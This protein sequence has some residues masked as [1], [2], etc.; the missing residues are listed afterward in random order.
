VCGSIKMVAGAVF[1]SKDQSI[2]VLIAAILLAILY[3][4]TGYRSIALSQWLH[5]PAGTIK[6]RSGYKSDKLQTKVDDLRTFFPELRRSR[7]LAYSSLS[8]DQIDDRERTRARKPI[9]I[10]KSFRE[11]DHGCVSPTGFTVSEILQIGDFPDY[12]ALSGFPLPEPAMNFDIETAKSRP[13]RP[14]RWP[15][16]QTMGEHRI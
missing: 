7:A 1:L 10:D 2:I 14:F 8:S 16:H 9:P 15:Y 3:R 11:I 13:F 5:N 6:R 4:V 12:A